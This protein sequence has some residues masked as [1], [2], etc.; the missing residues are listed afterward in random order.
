MASLHDFLW[1]CT[2]DQLKFRLTLLGRKAP[3]PRKGDCIEAVKQAYAGG[4]LRELWNSLGEL[5]RLAVAEACH[6]PGHWFHEDRFRAKY[7]DCPVFYHIPEEDRFQ[8]WRYESDPKHAT[9]LH[10]LVFRSGGRQPAFIPD[11]LAARLREFV[12]EPAPARIRGSSAPPPHEGMALDRCRS[13][14]RS[15]ASHQPFL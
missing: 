7:G 12:A 3:S 4:G 2:V 6:A 10:L 9:R 1:D 14:L 15:H 13:L 8:S 5:E 11:D